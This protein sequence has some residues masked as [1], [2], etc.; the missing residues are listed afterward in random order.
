V[1]KANV[2]GNIVEPAIII[3]HLNQIFIPSD[4]LKRINWPET[5]HHQQEKHLNT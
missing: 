1:K 2:T 3:K 5:K 4:V